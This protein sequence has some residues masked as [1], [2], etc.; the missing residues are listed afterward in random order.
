[1]KPDGRTANCLRFLLI[2]IRKWIAIIS[3]ERLDFR[4]YAYHV[5]VKI[6][7]KLSIDLVGL[8]ALLGNFFFSSIECEVEVL[9]C[10]CLVGYRKKS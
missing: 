6:C 3:K 4:G 7:F 10:K 2:V 1:M 9:L 8:N 5:T